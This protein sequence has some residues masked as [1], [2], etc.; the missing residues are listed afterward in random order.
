MKKML[1]ATISAILIISIA[2][3]GTQTGDSSGSGD[4]EQTITL[5][6]G[7]KM[8]ADSLDGQAFQMFADLVEE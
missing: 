3:C 8:T 5:R 4:N 7:H 2:S 6:L 1:T